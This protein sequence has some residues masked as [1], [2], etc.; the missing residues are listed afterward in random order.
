M[1]TSI[2]SPEVSARG[3]GHSGC[4]TF[5]FATGSSCSSSEQCK[6]LRA[7]NFDHLDFF[8]EDGDIV[9]R[10]RPFHTYARK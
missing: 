2:R 4:V 1:L 8:R 3:N 9:H 5:E 7:L 6:S 10:I